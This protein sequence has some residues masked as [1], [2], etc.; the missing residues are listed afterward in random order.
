MSQIAASNSASAVPAGVPGPA[1]QD[2]VEE[3]RGGEGLSLRPNLGLDLT[4]W[5][6]F[7][8]G[9]TCTEAPC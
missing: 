2:G 8:R 6:L 5:R 4:V 3:R 9:L 1:R 7:L